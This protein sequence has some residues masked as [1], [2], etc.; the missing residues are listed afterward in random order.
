MVKGKSILFSLCLVLLTSV[1]MGAGL[2]T[3]FGEVVVQNLRIGQTYNIRDLVNLP[4]EVVN[5]SDYPVDLVMQVEYPLGGPQLR[6]EYEPIPSTD[7]IKLTETYFTVEPGASAITDVIISI[8][9]DEKYLGKKYQVNI[10][11]EMTPGQR[12]LVA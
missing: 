4:L 7:W 10:R 1:A 8:P 6:K 3:Y 12:M 11:S 2:K 9:D 5:T